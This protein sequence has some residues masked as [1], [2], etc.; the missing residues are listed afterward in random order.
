MGK[1]LYVPRVEDKNSHMRMLNISSIDDLI[2]NSMKILEPAS[3]DGDGNERK[4]GNYKFV[5]VYVVTTLSISN[6][7]QAARTM[8]NL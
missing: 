3:V 7:Q 1:T 4:N 8:N 6:D 5:L 2:A